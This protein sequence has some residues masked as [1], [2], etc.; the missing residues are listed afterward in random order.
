MLKI[1][2]DFRS[3]KGHKDLSLIFN[4]LDIV[5]VADSYYFAID[6]QVLP[7]SESKDKVILIL[8]N[9]IDG[10]MKR[11]LALTVNEITFLPFDFSDQYLGCL[12]VKQINSVEISVCYGITTSVSG[13][14][15]SPS[16]IGDLVISENDFEVTSY[17]VELNKHAF[18]SSIRQSLHI[19]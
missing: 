15:I 7:Q 18:V 9:L 6:N 13:W 3:D 4:E 19:E 5:K 17:T 8:K 10:W 12:M 16:I 1:V 14:E 11:V 2:Y